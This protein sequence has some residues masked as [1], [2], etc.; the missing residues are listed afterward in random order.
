V[1][2]ALKKRVWA[3][4]LEP[5]FKREAALERAYGNAGRSKAPKG[6]TP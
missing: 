5:N 4:T 3:V 2:E 6:E 1:C